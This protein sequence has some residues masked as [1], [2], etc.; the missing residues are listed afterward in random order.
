MLD[1][2]QPL[3]QF[4]MSTAGGAPVIGAN[5]LCGELSS[6]LIGRHMSFEASVDLQT[7]T[8]LA[9][10]IMQSL[11]LIS[12]GVST[13]TC[14]LPPELLFTPLLLRRPNMFSFALCSF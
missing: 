8:L 6:L 10:F 13:C 2:Q 14:P 5:V 1:A 9:N 11:F 7:V 3:L 12:S 4:H